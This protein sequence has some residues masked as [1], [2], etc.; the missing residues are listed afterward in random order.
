MKYIIK[1]E[2]Q[3]RN[4]VIRVIKMTEMYKDKI[5]NEISYIL[6]FYQ[7]L[8]IDR[9]NITEDFKGFNSKKLSDIA[10]QIQKKEHLL[11]ISLKIRN[12]DG[13]DIAYYFDIIYRYNIKEIVD[14]Y[15]DI[16]NMVGKKLAINVNVNEYYTDKKSEK[17]WDIVEQEIKKNN[18]SKNIFLKVGSYGYNDH[19]RMFSDYRIMKCPSGKSL[20]NPTVKIITNTTPTTLQDF[21]DLYEKYNK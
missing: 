13:N 4:F 16:S 14:M 12:W 11:N 2:Y 15:K 19:C 9:I 20:N 17:Y 10:I 8:S 7:K 18:L 1:Y 6:N 5:V 3:S 21:I